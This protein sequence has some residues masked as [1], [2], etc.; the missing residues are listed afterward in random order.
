MALSTQV[1]P[2]LLTVLDDLQG[3]RLA[4]VAILTDGRDT[5]TAPLAEAYLRW[6]TTA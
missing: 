3:Q 1:I 2:S 4:G 6:A 5:P